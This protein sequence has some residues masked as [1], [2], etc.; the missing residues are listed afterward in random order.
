M[1]RV[2]LIDDEPLAR[3]ELRRLISQDSE[4]EIAGEAQSGEDALALLAK[5]KTDVLF[6]DIEMPGMSGLEVASRL[7]EWENPP[8]VVFATA[9]H[10]YAVEAFEAHAMD[11]VLKPF[12]PARL[13]KTLQ[14]VKDE[15][16][17]LGSSRESLLSLQDHLI[18][19]GILKKLTGHLRNHKDRV[20]VDPAEVYYFAAEAEEAVA[21]AGEQCLMIKSSL[22]DILSR[23]DPGHFVQTHKAYIVNINRI[24]KVSPMF[25]GNFEITFKGAP[26]L[27][28]PLSR[29]YSAGLKKL[30]GSW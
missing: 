3:G 4:F 14:R 28:I 26:S 6:L 5:Q 25:S 9:Y 11:Y 17:S 23:L 24:Q 15:L 7:A 12:E 18:D 8:R 22:K 27:R 30:L 20:V 2:L 29:R 13:K 10:Q 16:R 1:I 21:Y 19:R